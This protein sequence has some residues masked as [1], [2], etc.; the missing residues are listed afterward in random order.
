MGVVGAAGVVAG[1]APALALDAGVVPEEG[2]GDE[3][4][5]VPEG[6]DEPDGVA[7]GLDAAPA[8][9][10]AAPP[11]GAVASVFELPPPPLHPAMAATSSTSIKRSGRFARFMCIPLYR[12]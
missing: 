12:A 10:A 9:G 2:V 6:V 11:D 3:G 1:V 5:V 8:P 7:G 4:E